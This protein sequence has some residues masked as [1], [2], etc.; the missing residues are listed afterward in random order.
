M[1]RRMQCEE[2]T[3]LTVLSWAVIRR[4]F[5]STRFFLC[6]FFFCLS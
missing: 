3:Q 4:A 5:A 6:L 1:E 2:E